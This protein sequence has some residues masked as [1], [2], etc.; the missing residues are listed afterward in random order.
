MNKPALL[1]GSPVRAI[2]YPPYNPIDE[3]ARRRADAVLESG[4]LSGFVGR[5]NAQFYGGPVVLELEAALCRR[6]GSA[7]AVTVNS[8]TSGLHAALLAAG[9]GPGDEVIVPPITMSATAS[10]VL[11]CG[12]T[13]VFAD[14]EPDYFCLDPEAVRKAVRPATRAIVAVNL[15][16][17]PAALGEL[18]DIADR[19]GLVLVEDSAQAPGA[20]Y[21]GRPAGTVGHMGVLSFNRHKTV[22]CGE[23]G[24]VLTDDPRLAKRLQLLRNHGEVVVHDWGTGEDNDIVGYNYRLTDLQAAV[25]IPQIARLDD[26]NLPRIRLAEALSMALAPFDFLRTPRLRPG[27]SHVYYLYPIT[28]SPDLLGLSQ[29]TFVKAASAEGVHLSA[30]VTPIGNLPVFGRAIPSAAAGPTRLFEGRATGVKSA[31][32]PVAERMASEQLVVT[33]ICRPPL[34]MREIEEIAEAIGKVSA[35]REALASWER[36]ESG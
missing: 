36:G 33:N 30:Y 6:F 28:Y 31:A 2:P 34:G 26:L 14:I 29:N 22:Q 16:G 21:E 27:T 8:A 11:M 3:E 7:H 23:G 32:C 12:A 5:G 25:V 24:A 15:F 17:Q 13:P 9:I 19:N 4:L 18:R 10:A 1:G 20:M 35:N